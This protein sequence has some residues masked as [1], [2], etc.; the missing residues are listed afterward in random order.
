MVAYHHPPDGG[1]KESFPTKVI[2]RVQTRQNVNPNT[3]IIIRVDSGCHGHVMSS[4]P[5][6]QKNI[7]NIFSL[8]PL[9]KQRGYKF[10]ISD[11]EIIISLLKAGV[12]MS[13]KEMERDLRKDPQI[14]KLM[15]D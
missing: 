8:V 7:E 5:G 10:I 4:V 6:Q 2:G 11:R 12:K 13:P 9:W 15:G 1:K 3:P 14:K